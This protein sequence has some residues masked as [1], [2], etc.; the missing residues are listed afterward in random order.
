MYYHSRFKSL[1]P[2]GGE[3]SKIHHN[4]LIHNIS[5]FQ[6][7]TP[8]YFKY[9]YVSSWGTEYCR[10]IFDVCSISDSFGFL[11][12]RSDN[13]WYC[14]YC[15]SGVNQR[16]YSY[17]H[18]FEKRV[19]LI[20]QWSYNHLCLVNV[21]DTQLL[22]VPVCRLK[23][24]L[25]LW[26]VETSY[27]LHYHK[28]PNWSL[29]FNFCHWPLKTDELQFRWWLQFGHLW[30]TLFRVQLKENDFMEPQRVVFT[31]MLGQYVNHSPLA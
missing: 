29:G 28:Y 4:H 1:T 11:Q 3:R 15:T 13:Y 9:G 20:D 16:W 22:I 6:I 30:Y 23:I 19:L 8:K 27:G 26:R 12:T 5:S 31:S 10:L 2:R 21:L 24:T 7:R 18:S 25:L 17:L 14:S